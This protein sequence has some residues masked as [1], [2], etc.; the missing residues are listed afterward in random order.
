VIDFSFL[1]NPERDFPN[2]LAAGA[3][4]EAITVPRWRP[5]LVVFL[6]TCCLLPRAWAAWRCDLLWSDTILY[7]QAG[8]ALARGDLHEA[9]R[10]FGLNVYPAIL[11]GFQRLGL[12][13]QVAGK[14]WSVLFATLTVLPLWGWIRRQFDDRVAV[15]A[16]LAYAFHGKLVSISPLILRDPTFWF[17]FAMT[18]YCAWR[19][20]S[21]ARIAFFLATGALLTLAVFTRTE[22]CLLVIPLVGWPLC[23]LLPA[24]Q[25]R[26]AAAGGGQ[27]CEAPASAAAKTRATQTRFALIAG[28]I[29]GLSL[30]PLALV[31]VNCSVLRQHPHWELLRPEHTERFVEWWQAPQA[32]ADEDAAGA[33]SGL[34]RFPRLVLARKIVERLV[35]SFTYI[36]MLLTLLG[37]CAG[38]RVFFRREHQVLLV[39][40]L[41]L[42][43]LIFIYYHSRSID[44]RYFMPMVLVALPWMA[45]GFFQAVAWAAAALERFAAVAAARRPVIV[46]VA[47]LIVLSASMADGHLAAER[48]MYRQ[49]AV[50]LWIRDHLGPG[51]SLSSN[52]SGLHLIVFFAQARPLDQFPWPGSAE[53]PL[54][55]AV[56]AGQA[57]VVVLWREDSRSAAAAAR[58]R[59]RL[60][61]R[62]GYHHVAAEELP[63]DC[64][65][66]DL[67]LRQPQPTRK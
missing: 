6:L 35:K 44:I 29:L 34:G 66:V 49:R 50:G 12:D 9:F 19:A 51:Q 54:S 53:T 31:L 32:A 61:G 18:L 38:W 64:R 15:A 8:D 16:C 22:G 48:L 11:A 17:L 36:G 56:E 46:G 20:V 2:A 43:V 13:W 5:W 45:L 65:D 4:P 37:L 7:V 28:P 55:P 39:M 14:W 24:R 3:A 33:P 47:A 1:T 10:E 40:N 25:K 67:F 63:P 59:S 60:E 23:R 58:A 57:A 26:E 27:P 41:L 21:E 42:L 62:L 30:A 52:V